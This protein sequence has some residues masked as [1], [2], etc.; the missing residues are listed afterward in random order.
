MVRR[1]AHLHD[2]APIPPRLMGHITLKDLDEHNHLGFETFLEW[3]IN[4]G[5]M[6]EM[7]VTSSEDLEMRRIAREVNM[8][9]LDVEK[10]KAQFNHFDS[11]HSG[12][13]DEEEFRHIV[14]K[15]WRVENVSDVP[16]NT[17]RRIWRQIDQDGSG[18][19]DFQEFLV[20]YSNF[21]QFGS[22]WTL[23]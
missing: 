18:T 8:P 4:V 11:D 16:I 15:L 10:V 12:M 17:L 22:S 6:E 1:R 23:I 5:W 7:Q 3:S 20:W 19:I 2:G 13:I 14:Y 21:K 9:I